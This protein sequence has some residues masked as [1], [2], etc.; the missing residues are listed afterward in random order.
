MSTLRK[1]DILL[2]TKVEGLEKANRSINKLKQGVNA[3]SGTGGS[4]IG[5][6]AKLTAGYLSFQG[7]MRGSRFL[8]ETISG[9]ESLTATLRTLNGEIEGNAMPKSAEDMARLREIALD[10]PFTLQNVG[11]A[12]AQLKARGI[13]VSDT[14]RVMKS[15]G[16][17]AAAF[18]QDITSFANA[19]G[20]AIAGENERLKQ[21]GISAKVQGK[22]VAFTYNG[23]TKTVNRNIDEISST[24]L[25][26]GDDAQKGQ[27]PFGG[28]FA[29][30]AALQAKTI[31]GAFSRLQ[32]V[33]QIFA[34]ELG[35]AGL[36]EALTDLMGIFL[37]KKTRESIFAFAR[38]IGQRAGEA[39]RKFTERVKAV[40]EQ[41]KRLKKTMTEFIDS[42]PEFLKID[43]ATEALARF[44]GLMAAI[45][46]AKAIP[47]II[48]LFSSLGGAIVSAGGIVAFASGLAQVAA[49]LAIVFFLVD[50]IITYMNGG[51][52][53]LGR[54]LKHVEGAKDGPLAALRE[55]GD[56]LKGLWVDVLQ[57]IA[58]AFEIA[59]RQQVPA[60]FNFFAAVFKA[61]FAVAA[62]NFEF[63]TRSI[64]FFIG[65]FRAIA[66]VLRGDVKGA[67]N[68]VYRELMGLIEFVL[69][70]VVGAF[71]HLG[72]VMS[73][74][75]GWWD[76]AADSREHVSNF[77]ADGT[78]GGTQAS[79]IQG[80]SSLL[81][82]GF[83]PRAGTG[84]GGGNNT[85]NAPM[86]NNI[87]INGAKE[88]AA[89][90]TAVGNVLKENNAG[91]HKMTKAQFNTT[92]NQL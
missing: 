41:F 58:M 87:T 30:G 26:F 48:S 55:L 91:L 43:N 77:V 6:F 63:L 61:F 12:F 28:K 20:Q 38:V 19:V 86:T 85:V 56:G 36:T 40:P 76:A 10:T 35:K 29:G 67:V 51:D 68:V 46:A 69:G 23:I 42:L 81:S 8:F 44:G 59:F 70:N 50:D 53:M 31:G 82:T 74:L 71:E 37:N 73:S 62:S 18:G 17:T 24:L 14:E 49:V 4:L 39:V 78:V 47:M 22:Q 9:F 84:G 1:Y 32:D 57:P 16:N 65:L 54:F 7:V 64:S 60:A 92:K 45:A 3:L 34:F 15:V 72:E 90:G 66:M 80:A 2:K 75:V 52:S 83:A 25:A 88:P 27:G 89:S 33:A 79:G 13:D 5:T 21:F 11:K